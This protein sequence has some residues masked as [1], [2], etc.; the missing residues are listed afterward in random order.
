M[1]EQSDLTHFIASNQ[2][3]Q[4]EDKVRCFLTL[5]Y[6]TTKVLKILHEK[7][8]YVLDIK[9]DNIFVCSDRRR[10]GFKL[11]EDQP[12]YTFSF[13]DLDMAQI[14][15]KE[16]GKN[17]CQ[18]QL[19]TLFFLPTNA[20]GNPNDF[21]N[22]YGVQGYTIRDA[23]ALSKTLLVAFNLLMMPNKFILFNENN[24]YQWDL[25]PKQEQP[26]AYAKYMYQN[27]RNQQWKD[28]MKRQRAAFIDV[29]N[30]VTL[31]ISM[32]KSYTDPTKLLAVVNKL[33]DI[34]LLTSA[35]GR[36][37]EKP[38]K[39]VRLA[40]WDEMPSVDTLHMEMQKVKDRAREAGAKTWKR[41]TVQNKIRQLINRR[42][43]FGVEEERVQQPLSDG[44]EEMRCWKGYRP[45]RGKRR[46]SKGSCKRKVKDQLKF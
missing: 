43:G 26:T 5:V 45:V 42:R 21:R 18:S 1:C 33:F 32:T 16:Y 22:L 44:F 9:P 31:K 46:Y 30:Q 24:D 2:I 15:T 39:A 25:A 27:M 6:D 17:G 12:G 8:V 13:G 28:R 20:F 29:A 40:N 14:C 23:Y 37:V 34:L 35:T 7:G 19:A 41:Q 10:K 4:Y 11:S 38:G 36:P 3:K